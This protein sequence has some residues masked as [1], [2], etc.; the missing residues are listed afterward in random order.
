[1]CTSFKLAPPA[2]H[3]CVLNR[4]FDPKEKWPKKKWTVLF[5]FAPSNSFFS[6]TWKRTMQLYVLGQPDPLWHQNNTT[7]GPSPSRGGH[8]KP[9]CLLQCNTDPAEQCWLGLLFTHGLLCTDVKTFFWHDTT[10][11]GLTRSRLCRDFRSDFF[12]PWAPRQSAEVTLSRVWGSGNQSY[13]F[14]CS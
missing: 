11:S 12:L 2:G 5:Y 4:Y 13:T 14:P 6:F 1:M 10:Y 8:H 3:K 7:F 9:F